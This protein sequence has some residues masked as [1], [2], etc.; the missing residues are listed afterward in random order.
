MIAKNFSHPSNHLYN[1][2][3]CGRFGST[4][5][6]FVNV[7]LVTN[8]YRETN[9]LPS[10]SYDKR[11]CSIKRWWKRSKKF[12]TTT[13]VANEGGHTLVPPCDETV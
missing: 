6:A 13:I 5:T 4:G 1:P 2:L 7:L 10:S 9:L 11:S 8:L 12:A 3:A